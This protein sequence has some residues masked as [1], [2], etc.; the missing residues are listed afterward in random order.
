MESCS[1]RSV[2]NRFGKNFS[3]AAACKSL[4]KSY[5]KLVKSDTPAKPFAKSRGK[6]VKSFGKFGALCGKMELLLKFELVKFSDELAVSL[7]SA[8]AEF[9]DRAADDD[10]FCA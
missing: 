8:S 5:G 2:L 3:L 7:E 1:F 6:P 9:K 10:T 4:V